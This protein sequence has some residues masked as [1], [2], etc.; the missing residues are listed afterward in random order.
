MTL[1]KASSLSTLFIFSLVVA[2]ANEPH[3]LRPFNSPSKGNGTTLFTRLSP[4]ESG[5]SHFN[6]H[7]WNHPRA[8]LYYSGNACGGVAVGDLNGDELPDLFLSNGP[9]EN[10][11]YFQTGNLS[12]SNVTAEAG[13]ALSSNIWTAGATLLDIDNDHDLDI[14]VYNYDSPNLLY[15]NDGKGRFSEEAENYGLDLQ[16]TFSALTTADYDR[17][18][19]LDLYLMVNRRFDEIIIDHSQMV[20]WENG[21]PKLSPQANPYFEFIN[22]HDFTLPH[23]M[24]AGKA[25][26]LLRN[27]G[28]NKKFTDVSNTLPTHTGDGLSA[29]WWDYNHDNWPDLYVCNDLSFPDHLYKNNGDGT[30]TEVTEE[31]LPQ[32]AW[33][34]MG[35]EIGDLDN[36][37]LV[38]LIVADMAFTSHFKAKVSMGDMT[39]KFY[40]RD[41]FK[42]LQVMR[43]NVFINSGKERFKEAGFLTGLASSD[44]TWTAKIVDLDNDGLQDIFYSNGSVLSV[45]PLYEPDPEV[46]Y[47]SSKALWEAYYTADSTHEKNSVFKNQGHLKFES[48]AT[49]WG[50]DDPG[51]SY[52]A[53]HADLDRDGD[54]DLIVANVEEEVAIYRNDLKPGNALRVSLKGRKSNSQGIG[55]EISITSPSGKQFRQ[56]YP[57]TGYKTHNESTAHFGLGKDTRVDNITIQWPSGLTQ[58]ISNIPANHEVLFDEQHARSEAIEKTP[59]EPLLVEFPSAVIEHHEEYYDDFARQPLLPNQLSQLGPSMAWGDVDGDQDPDL[60]VGEGA[61]WPSMLYINHG[62][63]GLI[64]RPQ[65]AFEKHLQSEDMGSLFLDVDRDGDLDLYVGSGGVECEANDALLK[66]RLYLNDGR[67]NFSD[68]SAQWL[69]ELRNSTGPVSAADFDRDGDLDLFVGARSVPGAY[70]TNPRH[71]L[72]ENKGTHFEDVIWQKAPE[73][74]N[75]GMIASAIWTYSD[76][77]EW[78]DLMLATDWGP[79]RH[80]RNES[81]KFIETTVE[82]GLSQTKG[83]WSS[84]SSG[85]FDQDGDLD[86]IAGNTGLNTKYHPS[87]EKPTMIYY[88][89]FG[90]GQK[91]IVEAKKG[92]PE[93]AL[94]PVRG[95][96]CSS[97]AMPFLNEKF[98][99]YKDFALASLHEIYT[100]SCLKDAESYQANYLHSVCL[101]NDGN[102]KFSMKE[103]PHEAQIA[104]IFGT[105]ILDLNQ[106]GHLDLLAAQNFFTP[107]RETFPMNGGVGLTLL[108]NGDGSFRVLREDYSGFYVPK[109]AKSLC[110]VDIDGDRSPEVCVGSNNDTLS[111]FSLG[112]P[113]TALHIEGAPENK[114]AIGTK[115]VSKLPNGRSTIIEVQA[116]SGYLSQST[117]HYSPPHETE[118]VEV[119]WGDGKESLFAFSD[120]LN[121]HSLVH[122]DYKASITKSLDPLTFD[123]MKVEEHMQNG[124]AELIKDPDNEILHRKILKV[125]PENPLALTALASHYFRQGKFSDAATLVDKIMHNHPEFPVAF[126]TAIEMALANKHVPRAHELLELSIVK[127]PHVPRFQFLKGKL[128]LAKGHF[129]EANRFF[130]SLGAHDESYQL[131]A[132]VST[133]IK[134]RI[135][136]ALAF[137][138]NNELTKANNQYR[139][140]LQLNNNLP[141]MR[142]N[143]VWNMATTKQASD[144]IPWLAYHEAQKLLPY[145]R[146]NPEYLET[147]VVA[148]ERTENNK[149]A[150]Q[151]LETFLAENNSSLNPESESK[152]HALLRRLQKR[153]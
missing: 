86:Y 15:I 94:L 128:F 148:Y 16:N 81:G 151:L 19:D 61:G 123:L 136:K 127:F 120:L 146:E 140:I 93:G 122:P 37:G 28:P 108:G 77:D 100:P 44:W 54:L 31:V 43:N 32:V 139:L 143:W 59:I 85:D 58:Q 40:E 7:D 9:G 91:R 11:L 98:T 134:T 83:W 22:Q 112:K 114:N 119:S 27:E 67:G 115:I 34:S 51:M 103:L 6:K 4:Q 20:Y 153:S 8:G 117:A 3:Q 125:A 14:Y 65:A 63:Q 39:T 1:F 29:V 66:D 104:P 73:L 130:E 5:I 129:D 147:I 110:L 24:Y 106:D 131:I 87:F 76:A 116:N 25:D 141:A 99:T 21:I 45:L 107:Q 53:A 97:K 35:S 78:P 111:M 95:K 62:K 152:L 124:L 74:Q 50:L 33:N 113:L 138:R 60:Y 49:T 96:S 133:E 57:T 72:L 79:I 12:F 118:S 82:A 56:A 30:F 84:L 102:G 46:T 101:I 150:I 90:D 89:D 80:F 71:A 70:P 135:N 18:G 75:S 41:H 13:V 149:E 42:P 64:P 52:S 142:N 36:D 69:P 126:S 68:A 121:T 144:Q 26:Y 10:S 23:T 109:D 132:S 38:D 137:Q 55:A 145:V 92:G 2:G 47:F 17:D 105:A 48:V 88:G